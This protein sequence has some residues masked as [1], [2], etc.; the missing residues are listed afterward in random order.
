[1]IRV[2]VDLVDVDRLARMVAMSGE[3]FIE[4][5][6]TAG[7]RSYCSGRIDRFAARWAAKEATMKALGAGLGE[8]DPLDI[9]IRSVEGSAP[10]ILLHRGALEL[11]G[12]MGIEGWGVS[13]SHEGRMAVAFVIGIGASVE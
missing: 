9:E 4:T 1:V 2:G 3:A 7:E 13:L 8:I 12:R 11:A 6:W 5:A 10:D